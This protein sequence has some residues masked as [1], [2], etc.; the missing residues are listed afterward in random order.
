MKVQ[1]KIMLLWMLGMAVLGLTPTFAI[2]ASAESAN[3]K[4]TDLIQELHCPSDSAQYG[5]FRDYGYWGGGAWCGQTGAAGYW[6]WVNPTWYVWRSEGNSVSALASANGTYSGLLQTL[7]CPSDSAQYG[8]FKDYGYWG[9]GA[10][11]GQNGSAGYWVWAN[12]NW[13]VWRVKR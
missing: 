2:A 9:G 6:V 1:H 12:P 13:Y 4:Y 8:Q 7:Y 3:G 10:W 11:C 5:N